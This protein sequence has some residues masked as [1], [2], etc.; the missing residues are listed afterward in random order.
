MCYCL[1]GFNVDCAGDTVCAS[2]C[3]GNFRDSNEVDCLFPFKYEGVWYDRCTNVTLGFYW[4]SIDREYTGRYAVCSEECPALAKSLVTAGNKH[5]AC[6]PTASGFVGNLF[7]STNYWKKLTL[8]YEH[9][10]SK[11]LRQMIQKSNK[12]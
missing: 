7:S 8:D 5:T 11:V 4:C 1:G 10:N 3:N 6:L 9:I 12:F 2:D